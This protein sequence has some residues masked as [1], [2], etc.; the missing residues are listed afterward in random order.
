MNEGTMEPKRERSQQEALDELQR[1]LNVRK[2]CFPRWVGDGRVSA[3]DAQ[4]RIDRLAT[5]ITLLAAAVVESPTV[6]VRTSQKA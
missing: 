6:E 3:T 2:R 4:D 5:A 1:E